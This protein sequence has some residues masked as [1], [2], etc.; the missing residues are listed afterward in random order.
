MNIQSEIEFFA[1]LGI[2]DKARFVT[3]LIHEMCEEA[4][5]GAGDGND[6][7][8]LRFANEMGQRLARFAYQLLG[9]DSARPQDDVVVRMLLGARA[10]KKIERIVH[11]AYRRVLTSFESF[12]T[13]VVFHA[14]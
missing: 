12:D 13:T 6:L 5:L 9:E 11:N 7:V 4:K 2:I 3:R 14:H 1:D 10:D 8:R